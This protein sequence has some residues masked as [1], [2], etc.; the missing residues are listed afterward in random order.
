M[1][2]EMHGTSFKYSLCFTMGAGHVDVW[3]CL[4]EISPGSA[5]CVHFANYTD[6]L[7]KYFLW[8]YV[9]MLYFS[10]GLGDATDPFQGNHQGV[11]I[12]QVL[13]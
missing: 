6:M 11:V 12:F 2:E 7:H 9:F 8:K 13:F 4:I 10:P 3:K 1:F 5:C